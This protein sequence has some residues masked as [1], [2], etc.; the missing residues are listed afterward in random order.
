[1]GGYNPL[2][3]LNA[4]P[5]IIPECAFSFPGG[6]DMIL[7]E[8]SGISPS[9]VIA[10]SETNYSGVLDIAGEHASIEPSCS[11]YYADS[12][13]ISIKY[14]EGKYS[15]YLN[16]VPV[17]ACNVSRSLSNLMAQAQLTL[18]GAHWYDPYKIQEIAIEYESNLLFFGVIAQCSVSLAGGIPSTTIQACDHFYRLSHLLVPLLQADWE[19]IGMNFRCSFEGSVSPDNIVKMLL[20]GSHWQQDT[21]IKPGSYIYPVED[22][23]SSVIFTSFSPGT[24]RLDAIKSL[25]DKYGYVTYLIYT[26]IDDIYGCELYWGPY[27]N[28]VFDVNSQPIIVDLTDAL[29]ATRDSIAEMAY[30]RIIVENTDSGGELYNGADIGYQG[31]RLYNGADI[32][33]QGA[34]VNTTPPYL[35][36]RVAT[37]KDV[38]SVVTDATGYLSNCVSGFNVSLKIDGVDLRLMDI[39][40]IEAFGE[41]L[42]IPAGD[43]TLYRMIT[44]VGYDITSAGAT[45]TLGTVHQ[46]FELIDSTSVSSTGQKDEVQVIDERIQRALENADAAYT[47]ESISISG[48]YRQLQLSDGRRVTVLRTVG[49]S[50]YTTKIAIPKRHTNIWISTV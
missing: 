36:K 38:G 46:E 31:A 47:G 12:Y 30:N 48:V 28:M 26:R 7:S 22:W 19:R 41:L 11:I 49:S 44:S 50:S 9:C 24:T 18:P 23:S 3:H 45:T 5:Y 40:N 29:S 21:G 42:G 39:I 10:D 33:Y 27:E 17:T 16:D 20:G 37:N 25:A 15:L 32:G 2:E 8:A 13:P 6:N 1:M 14:L 35:E 4:Y 43:D 34:R